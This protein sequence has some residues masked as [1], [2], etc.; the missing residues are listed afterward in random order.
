MELYSTKARITLEQENH[1]DK[2]C[3]IKVASQITDGTVKCLCI[4]SDKNRFI[5]GTSR[6]H[7][8]CY[9]HNENGFFQTFTIP[10]GHSMEVTGVS[11]HP[12]IDVNWVSA[13]ADKTCLLWDKRLVYP[14]RVLTQ[15]HEECFSD[16]HWYDTETIVLSDLGGN[17]T[18]FDIRNTAV[19]LSKK[20]VANRQ[21]FSLH[22]NKNKFGI[23]SESSKAIIY[24][25]DEKKELKFLYEHNA[26]PYM[27]NSLCWDIYDKK[28]TFYVV[29]D[30][31]YAKEISLPAQE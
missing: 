16:V 27:I 29:G 13:S 30:Q 15:D 17:V 25:L 5:I 1:K 4:S 2:F 19:P 21:I 28:N 26:H 18:V 10:Y 23:V 8:E 12:S 22:Y 14:A 20:V 9:E 11:A 24:E 7:F 6:G 31:K 3:F